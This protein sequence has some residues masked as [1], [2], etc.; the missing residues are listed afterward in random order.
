MSNMFERPL[1]EYQPVAAPPEESGL[2]HNYEIKG[3]LS[4]PGLSKILGLSAV[5]NI[6]AMLVVAQTS[7]LTMKGCDSPLVGSVCQVLDTVYVGSLLFGTDREYVDKAYDRTELGPDDDITYI[8]AS[9]ITPPLT[10]PAGYFQIANPEETAAIDELA[11]NDLFTQGI[12]GIPNGIPLSQPSTG[13]SLF[14]TKP[15]IPTPNPNVIDE[16]TLP[17]SNGGSL[18]WTK[19][20]KYKQWKRSKN[21]PFATAHP[22]SS[23]AGIPNPD[24]EVA[25]KAS[26]SLSASPTSGPNVTPLGPVADVEIN[27][28]PFVDL[29]NDINRLLDQK[30]VDLGTPFLIKATGKLDKNGKLDRKSFSYT[31]AK[32]PDPIAGPRMIE[33]VKASIEAV[34]ASNFLQYLTMFSGKDLSF[35]IFQDDQKVVAVVQSEFETDLRANTMSTL[36]SELINRKKAAKEAAD[37]SPSDKDDLVFL[38]NAKIEHPGKK[39]VVTFIVPKADVQNMLQRKLA[40]LRAE[41]KAENT[42]GG[43]QKAA[44]PAVK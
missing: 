21:A 34:N 10:Y 19:N 38:Q 22:E 28:R 7:L 6:V 2:F 17:N 26:P 8:D 24:E 40:E 31:D 23:P 16:S 35:E 3:W 9:N 43:M 20:P 1:Y 12:P 39:L 14:D 44:D 36:L 13:N 33:V 18:A 30:A 15:N 5:V 41:P 29:G 4:R 37:A 27:K 42:T 25:E 32:S 11:A